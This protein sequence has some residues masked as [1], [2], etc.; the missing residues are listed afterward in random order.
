[1]QAVAWAAFFNFISAFTFGTSVAGTVGKGFVDTHIVTVYV[2]LAGVL[3]AII[4]DLIT[5]W[6]AL[7]TS[8]SHAVIGGYAGAAVA[9]GGLNALIAGKWALTL[10]FIVIAPLIGLI[11]AFIMIVL[12][13]WL[14]RKSTPPAWIRGFAS[15]NFCPPR[16]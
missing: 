11:A 8:S 3:G 4:W 7:P 5:W 9:R 6:L 2:I 15:C 13:Y 1:M 16:Y 12:V 14:F 10:S